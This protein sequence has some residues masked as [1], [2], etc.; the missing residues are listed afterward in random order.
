M[1]LRMYLRWA[2]REGLQAELDETSFPATRP[3][4]ATVV[5]VLTLL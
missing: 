5:A 2:E 1:L 4:A 3:S